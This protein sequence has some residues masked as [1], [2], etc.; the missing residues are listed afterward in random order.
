MP[1]TRH[2]PSKG[3]GRLPSARTLL[4]LAALA[5]AGEPRAAAPLTLEDA[6]RTAWAKNLG[7]AAG[8][9]QVEAARADASAATASLLPA[10]QLTARGVRT[11]EPLMAF[12]IKL[13]QGQITQ[14]DFDPARLNDPAA[15]TG[16]GAGVSLTQPIFAGGRILAGRRALAAQAGAEAASQERRAQEIAVA[17]VEAYF[18]AQVAAEGVKFAEDLLAQARETERFVGLRN[19]EGLALDADLARATAFRAQAEADR[20]AAV[21][22]L[23]S[24]RSALV[25]LAGDDVAGAALATPVEGGEAPP[26]PTGT[27]GE[28]PDLAAAR[29]RRD[30]ARAGVAAARGSLLPEVG[31]QASLETLRTSDLDDG[32]SWYALGVVAKW[33]LTVADGARL[34]A[35][36]ARARAAEAALGWQA[37]EA[38]RE[39]AEARRALETADARVRSAREAV[40]ASESARALRAARHRQGL[41]PLTDLLDAEA[42]LAG[43]RALL[44]ASRLEARVARAKLALADGMPV[45]GL[46]P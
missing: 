16:W 31:A 29:L 36:R 40:A 27:G 37:R 5:L 30:A 43:A 7:L 41:T 35:A 25:L 3:G 23:E 21:Q 6:V 44:L 24:A 19:R 12:G 2:A 4:A 38:A 9:A 1:V 13:D 33:Q 46:K 17:V 26:A 32:T 15:I 28:R 8:A 39:G 20:A 18:G 14:Q 10:L 22:R 34:R 11:D 45:E 42:G